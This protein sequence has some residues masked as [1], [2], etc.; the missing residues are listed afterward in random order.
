MQKLLGRAPF[1]DDH[2]PGLDWQVTT[3]A[4]LRQP[5]EVTGVPMLVR[6][7]WLDAGFA[8]GALR[9]FATL[10]NQQEVEIGPW[11]HGGGT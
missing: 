11:G 2:L 9:R 4:A 1:S 10:S 6:A 8:A 3:P 7:G 5:V